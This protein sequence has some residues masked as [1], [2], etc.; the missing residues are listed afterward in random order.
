MNP[1]KPVRIPDHSKIR[2]SN[3]LTDVKKKDPDS[4]A[5]SKFASRC[6]GAQVTPHG[7]AAA[8]ASRPSRHKATT[9]TYGPALAHGLGVEFR[10]GDPGARYDAT[11][12]VQEL[13]RRARKMGAGALAGVEDVFKSLGV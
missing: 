6:A 8:D 2:G 10:D 5:V 13:P 4:R 12:A 3:E 1:P 7:P 9:Q 11:R